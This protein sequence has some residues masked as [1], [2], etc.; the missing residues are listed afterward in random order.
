MRTLRQGA[1]GDSQRAV[2][3]ARRR[4]VWCSPTTPQCRHTRWSRPTRASLEGIRS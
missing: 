3:R 4:N 1:P 2:R